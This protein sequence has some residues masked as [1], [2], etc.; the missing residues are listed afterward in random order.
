M[1]MGKKLFVGIINMLLMMLRKLKG[2]W[3]I[4][5]LYNNG[6]LKFCKYSLYVLFEMGVW[7]I[8]YVF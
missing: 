7:R 4:I 1:G 3:F 5:L 6:F 8:L 2:L